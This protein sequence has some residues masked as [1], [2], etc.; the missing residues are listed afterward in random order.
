V[1]RAASQKVEMPVL[2]VWA[3]NDHALC[4]SNLRDIGTVRGRL[5]RLGG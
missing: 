5:G 4:L 2:V 1:E 3:A